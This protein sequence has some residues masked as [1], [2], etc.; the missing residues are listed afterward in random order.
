MIS[1]Q[2][3]HRTRPW[4]SIDQLPI[5]TYIAQSKRG[6]R[7]Y[8]LDRRSP[9]RVQRDNP[10]ARLL[11]VFHAD[12]LRARPI[13]ADIGLAGAWNNSRERKRK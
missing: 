1:A 12:S 4:H 5:H 13:C 3:M 6:G 9:S 8:I 11:V 10:A 7:E 2:H